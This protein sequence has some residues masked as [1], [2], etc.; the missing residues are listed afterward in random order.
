VARA[1]ESE[2]DERV[3]EEAADLLYHLQV[4][5]ASRGIPVATVLEVVNERAAEKGE[6]EVGK[7]DS[8]PRANGT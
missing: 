8:G 6:G 5:L 2:S 7:M 1:A 4:L 3:A